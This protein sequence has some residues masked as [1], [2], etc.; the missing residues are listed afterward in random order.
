[1]GG[2]ES[3]AQAGRV[4]AGIRREAEA[5]GRRIPDDH[6]GVG[7]FFRFGN[8]NEPVVRHE[9][10]KLAK[11]FP[12]RNP[13]ETTVVGNVADITAR[14]AEYAAVGVTKFVLRP[15]A[16]GDEDMMAQTRRLIEQGLPAIAAMNG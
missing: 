15:M 2:R 7:I 10:D 6:Y 16:S 3:P 8:E 9:L 13:A 14:I 5:L 12:D 11:R 4:V 1:M